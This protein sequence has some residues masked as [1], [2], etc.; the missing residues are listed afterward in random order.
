MSQANHSERRDDREPSVGSPGAHPEE[1]LSSA[2]L[3]KRA[4]VADDDAASHAPSVSTTD[5]SEPVTRDYE[6]PLSGIAGVGARLRAA[7]RRAGLEVAAL[8]ADLRL[9]PQLIE[10]IERGEVDTIPDAYLR[11]YVR[12]LAKVLGQDPQ[13]LVEALGAPE[14]VQLVP[15]IADHHRRKREADA[16]PSR[17][18]GPWVVALL[19]VL[20]IGGG[21]MA[22]PWIQQAIPEDGLRFSSLGS[23]LGAWRGGGDTERDASARDETSPEA[24]ARVPAVAGP[25]APNTAGRD[26]PPTQTLTLEEAIQP[27]APPTGAMVDGATTRSAIASDAIAAEDGPDRLASQ[28]GRADDPASRTAPSIVWADGRDVSSAQSVPPQSESPVADVQGDGAAGTV[29]RPGDAAAR[30]MGPETAS[31]AAPE[32]PPGIQPEI[33]AAIERGRAALRVVVS[34]PSWVEIRSADRDRVVSEV[35]GPGVDRLFEAEYPVRVVV[36]YAPG[37]RLEW[38]GEAYDLAPHGRGDATARFTLQAP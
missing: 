10:A 20:V 23:S 12:T 14:P 33:Q 17:S 24:M 7:R 6:V 1:T 15:N 31:M 26:G 2:P 25:G 4:S 16:G 36:G 9:K 19:L 29:G 34:Q 5:A 30:E 13:P 3:L 38:N 22:W 28:A 27:D 21:V 8:A 32:T 18:R 37:V 11:G 35:L